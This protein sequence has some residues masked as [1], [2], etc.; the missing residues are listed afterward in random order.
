VN[1]SILAALAGLAGIAMLATNPALA[2]APAPTPAAPKVTEINVDA[3]T[4]EMCMSVMDKK[5]QGT[6]THDHIGKMN[7]AGVK[8]RPLT[9]KEMDKVHAKCAAKLAEAG[10]K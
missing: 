8:K 2:Q 3:P 9:K 10:K 7:M 1:K 6:F 4:H 5:M